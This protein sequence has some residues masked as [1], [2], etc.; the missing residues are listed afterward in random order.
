MATSVGHILPLDFGY[1]FLYFQ[2]NPI[3]IS[4]KFHLISTTRTVANMVP[5]YHTDHD[6][7][8]VKACQQLEKAFSIT[9]ELLVVPNF[10]L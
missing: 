1:I 3:Q 7:G 8:N 4:L 9:V 10:N 6:H 5:G 2:T